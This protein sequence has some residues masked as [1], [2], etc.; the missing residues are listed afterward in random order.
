MTKNTDIF[1]DNSNF[2]KKCIHVLFSVFGSTFLK[3]GKTSPE[4]KCKVKKM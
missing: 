3:G 2:W 1:Y 4:K